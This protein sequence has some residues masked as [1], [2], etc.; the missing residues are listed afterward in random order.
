MEIYGVDVSFH[1][2][3]PDWSEAKSK[4]DF[5]LLG[6]TER[7]GKDASFEH[8]YTG[9]RENGI[10]IGGYKYSYARNGEE[11]RLEAD[12]IVEILAGRE[13]EFPIFIDLEWDYQANLSTYVRSQIIEQFKEGIEAGGYV[14]GGIYCNLYWY[15]NIIPQEAKNKYNFWIALPPYNDFGELIPSLKPDVKNMVGWQYSWCGTVPGFGSQDIDMDVFYTDY[16]NGETPTPKPIKEDTY[17]LLT[18]GSEGG[19]V[20]L[21]QTKLNSYFGNDKLDVDGIFGNETLKAV[22]KFQSAEGLE[23]DGV[24][25]LLTW[26][27][28]IGKSIKEVAEEVIAG[29]WG[30]GLERK[31]RL[32]EAGYD[33]EI[34]QDEVNRLLE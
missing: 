27:K 25:G 6:I 3:F 18:I 34:I 29:E 10:K 30:N 13:L 24:V 14:F 32:T 15:N 12:Q 17:P 22:K 33:Y 8:N 9:C 2:G 20:K 21:L 5:A 26:A 16:S 11:S 1:K 7:F 28:L 4:V 19:Y 23:E 31:N